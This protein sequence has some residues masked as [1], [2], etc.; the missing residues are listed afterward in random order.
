MTSSSVHIVCFRDEKKGAANNSRLNIAL[1]ISTAA[2][3]YAAKEH[4][5]VSKMLMFEWIFKM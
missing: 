1:R 5:D 4:K 2:G 3:Y